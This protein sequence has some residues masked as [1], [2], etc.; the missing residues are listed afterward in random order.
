M[1][2]QEFLEKMERYLA[3]V[4]AVERTRIINY[5]EEMIDDYLEDGLSMVDA[6]E[7]IGDPKVIATQFMQEVKNGNACFNN[8]IKGKWLTVITFPIWSILY[9]ALYVI[10]ICLPVSLLAIEGGLLMAGLV[11][12]LGSLMV[13]KKYNIPI[14]IVQSGIGIICLG[15][16]ISLLPL[17]LWLCM[18]VKI[19]LLRDITR[20]KR[21]IRG[22]S[23][24]G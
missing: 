11:S 22:I 9:F 1:N 7:M 10:L 18:K 21:F 23:L 15:L 13:M 2:K 6:V 5:Y 17:S 24:N 3:E 8:V 20:L 16:A 14:G 12:V 19:L 4:N